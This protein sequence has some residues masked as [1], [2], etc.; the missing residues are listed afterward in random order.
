ME[1]WMGYL[2]QWLPKLHLSQGVISPLACRWWFYRKNRMRGRLSLPAQVNTSKQQMLPF[3]SIRPAVI[4]P[5][6]G[7]QRLEFIFNIFLPLLIFLA[8]VLRVMVMRG[9]VKKRGAKPWELLSAAVFINLP[10]DSFHA[11]LHYRDKD[12]MVF[13]AQTV[14]SDAECVFCNLRTQNSVA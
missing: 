10:S 6:K 8:Q 4:Y 11:A 12:I 1:M 2:P 3:R 9:S 13:T 14:Y 7:S 5:T